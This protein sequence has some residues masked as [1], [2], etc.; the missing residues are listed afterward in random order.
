MSS[1][2][3]RISVD[4]IFHLYESLD[5]F[6]VALWGIC[7]LTIYIAWISVLHERCIFLL[8]CHQNAQSNV[9]PQF[10][11][12]SLP[13][14]PLCPCCITLCG[15]RA[16]WRT[17]VHQLWG[18]GAPLN[19]PVFH[20]RLSPWGF[21][22]PCCPSVGNRGGSICGWGSAQTLMHAYFMKLWYLASTCTPTHVGC[23]GA[24]VFSLIPSWTGRIPGLCSRSDIG[25]KNSTLTW[26]HCLPKLCSFS[27]NG[28]L[29]SSRPWRALFIQSGGGGGCQAL[30]V[31]PWSRLIINQ[32]VELFGTHC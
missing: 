18:Q 29:E 9:S 19:L 32:S 23:T 26:S 17:C 8:M 21:E 13:P 27:S 2:P 14:A 22:E 5:L 25:S 31:Q 24:A 16:L 7:T 12:G 11:S 4:N 20:T 3:V 1:I 6:W 15:H 30:H 28:T 10:L